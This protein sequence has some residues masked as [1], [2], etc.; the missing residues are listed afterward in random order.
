MPIPLNPKRCYWAELSYPFGMFFASTSKYI[1]ALL[2]KQIKLLF[3]DLNSEKIQ[4]LM[5]RYPS[6]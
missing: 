5:I 6:D 3:R 2:P 1:L 4:K